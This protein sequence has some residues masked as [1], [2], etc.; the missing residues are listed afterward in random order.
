VIQYLPGGRYSVCNKCMLVPT[1][2]RVMLIKSLMVCI[3]A[4]QQYFLCLTFL[5]LMHA[6]VDGIARDMH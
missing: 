1:L 3:A 4:H 6:M 2:D 5:V